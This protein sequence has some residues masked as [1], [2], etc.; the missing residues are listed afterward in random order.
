ML[1]GISGLSLSDFL[2]EGDDELEVGGD[3]KDGDAEEKKKGGDD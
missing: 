2:G 3:V 1:K